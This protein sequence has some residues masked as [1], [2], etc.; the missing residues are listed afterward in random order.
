MKKI[1]LLLSVHLLLSSCGQPGREEIPSDI[2][3]NS[4]NEVALTPAQVSNAEIEVGQ[5][6]QRHIHTT[7]RV[8][9][10]V[11]VPPS[12]KV[13]V[14]NPF[15][16]YISKMNLLPGARVK[17]GDVLAVMEDP[18]YIQ[19]QQDYL[20][21]KTRLEFLDMD[22]QR[23]RELN[24]DKSISDKTFQQVSSDHASHKIHMKALYE[25]LKLIDIDPDKLTVN[26][27]SGSVRILSPIQGYVASI[28]VNV[29]KYL[30][31]TD[32]L[33][34]LVDEREV[35]ISLTVFE[36]DIPHIGAGQKVTIHSSNNPEKAYAARVALINRSVNTDRTSEIH[37]E[38]EDHADD[39]SPGMFVSAEIQSGN[40]EVTTV[41]EGAV[42]TWDNKPYIFVEKSE[43]VFVMSPVETGMSSEGFIELKNILPDQSLVVKNA[44]SLLMKAKGDEE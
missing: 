31:P 40:R 26:N 1:F 19:L 7:I 24:I 10:S 13:S 12:H 34:E 16:G 22:F 4:S 39:L 23:Q 20:M 9:G 5:P 32:V 33:F 44:Y 30:N 14:T 11:D 18:Q 27:L 28:F 35:H 8:N 15:G 37:C 6:K 42:V 3:G 38:L 43:N 36:K 25:K 41:P 17:R 2:P 29:G 21:A